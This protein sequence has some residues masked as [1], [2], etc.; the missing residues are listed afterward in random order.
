[1]I[2]ISSK[3][4]N[5][6]FQLYEL[7]QKLKPLGYVIGGNWDYDHGNFDY[8]IADED[9]YQFLR[10][11]F[12]AIDGQLDSHGVTVKLGKPYLLS[13]E[14]QPGLDDQAGVGNFAAAF[15]QFSEPSDRD[16]NF[17]KKYIEIGKSLVDELEHILIVQ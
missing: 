5:N 7:E 1:M 2:P 11:P 8:K 14:Y 13:H 15:D 10:V 16:S 17:P 4:E 12:E 6:A 9:G 3:I